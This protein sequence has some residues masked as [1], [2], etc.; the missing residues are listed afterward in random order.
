MC[1][2]NLYPPSPQSSYTFASEAERNAT[3]AN[4]FKGP[5]EREFAVEELLQKVSG[6][7]D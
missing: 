2:G 4:V 6:S 3:A 5:A 1:R 7:G